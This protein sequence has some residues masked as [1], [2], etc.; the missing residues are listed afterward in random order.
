MTVP[1][2]V[3]PPTTAPAPP[4]ASQRP[5][6]KEKL[7]FFAGNF[8]NILLSTTISSFLLLYLTD[9]LGIAAAAVGTLLLVVRI[10]DSLVDPF[11]GYAVDHLPA[12]GRGR[13]RTYLLIGGV[14]G[15]L[16]FA[17]LF[18]APAL[19]PGP[20]VVAWIVYLLWGIA[21]PMMD[22][23]LN[24][25]LPVMT[26]DQKQRGSLAAIKGFTYLFGGMLVIAVTLPVVGMFSSE[27]TGWMLFCAAVAV[28]AVVCTTT[29]A[30]GV[31]ER[32]RPTRTDKYGPRDLLRIFSGGRAAG[33][34]L[35]AKVSTSAASAA[36]LAT[37][38]FYFLYNVG[39]KGLVTVA[40]LVMM[41]PMAGGSVLAPAL[42]ARI[43]GKPVYAGALTV[44][45]A[46]NATL[47]FMPYDTVPALM[48]CLAVAGFGIGAAV[49]LNYVLLAELT[50]YVEWRHGHRAEGALASLASFAAKAGGGLGGA[51]T[52]YCLGLFGYVPGAD[53]TQR[54][55]DGI[56]YAQAGVPLAL[57]LIGGGVFLAYPI[58][59]RVSV[60]IT[61]E[62]TARRATASAQG[63]S[64]D[65]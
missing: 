51:A 47:F 37:M 57:I 4:A 43:G 42:A 44:A 35:T 22:I 27:R 28:L 17:A 19:L 56:R 6:V 49:T 32:V 40:A 29:A 62:L 31:R 13:F 34:L 18:L 2:P 8:G 65:E 55:M 45:A 16:S 26:S 41:V 39:D 24:S 53:Q 23:P 10:I 11:V 64:D 60:T 15:G 33:V 9:V 48:C 12:T 21:F 3:R 20:L 14:L 52:A 61:E 50:D 63:T 58:T 46:G 1:V 5:S 59:R 30:L 25:L 7:S 36:T 38:P 54:A